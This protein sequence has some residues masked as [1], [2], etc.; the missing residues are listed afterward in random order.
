MSFWLKGDFDYT[1]SDNRVVWDFS[2][3][4][5]VQLGKH[6]TNNWVLNFGSG[7]DLTLTGGATAVPN[8]N[9]W[10]HICI[11]RNSS[12]LYTVYVDSVSKGSVTNTLNVGGGSALNF[13]LFGYDDY[14]SEY[15]KGW[16]DEMGIW[17]RVLTT[18]EISAL[19]NS[20]KGKIIY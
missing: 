15:W 9:G 11:T 20:G 6:P 17:Q 16:M 10:H 3:S 18:S 14:N 2:G 8:D 4:N 7:S 5:Q 13:C 19:Y 1:G 12:S